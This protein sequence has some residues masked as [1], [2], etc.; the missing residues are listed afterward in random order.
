MGKVLCSQ[1]N[2]MKKLTYKRMSFCICQS[3][4]PSGEVA[5][6]EAMTERVQGTRP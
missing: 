3:L 2:G 6:P 5:A 4:S 1:V